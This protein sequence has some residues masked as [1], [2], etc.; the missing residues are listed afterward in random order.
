MIRD[1]LHLSIHFMQTYDE[2]MALA[3]KGDNLKLDITMKDVG[4][5][6]KDD[7]ENRKDDDNDIYGAMTDHMIP[8]GYPFCCMAA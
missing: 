5:E 3:E 6:G 7:A 2:L 1:E 8:S 4:E